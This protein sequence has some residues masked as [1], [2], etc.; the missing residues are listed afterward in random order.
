MEIKG[1]M[2]IHY[3]PTFDSVSQVL[4]T[5]LETLGFPRLDIELHERG[6]NTGLV[7][8]GSVKLFVYPCNPARNLMVE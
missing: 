2:S 8:L 4:V 3:S 5:N 7:N 6:W 1:G